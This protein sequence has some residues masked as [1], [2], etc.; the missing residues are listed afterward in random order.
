MG[1]SGAIAFNAANEIAVDRFRRGMI[2]FLEIAETVAAV[3]ENTRPE[4][5]S[6]LQE[7]LDCD[8]RVRQELENGLTKA[9]E[10]HH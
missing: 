7:I 10:F 8:A 6:S 5:F 3:L 4:S 1:D 9:M 2:G